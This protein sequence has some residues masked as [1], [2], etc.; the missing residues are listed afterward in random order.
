MDEYLQID[1][2]VSI[3]KHGGII[4]LA[5]EAKEINSLKSN[6]DWWMFCLLITFSSSAESKDLLSVEVDGWLLDS[7]LRL[8]CLNANDSLNWLMR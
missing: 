1:E 7:N 8:S 2:S 5:L 3:I 6:C 4:W